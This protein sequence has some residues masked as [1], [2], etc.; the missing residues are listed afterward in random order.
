MRSYHVILADGTERD[1]KAE[2]VA[3]GAAGDLE[4]RNGR[5]VIVAYAPAAWRMVEVERKDDTA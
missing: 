2:S 4:L 3:I 5:E 1:I